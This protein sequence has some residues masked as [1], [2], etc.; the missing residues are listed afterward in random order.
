MIRSA[1]EQLWQRQKSPLLR[2]TS[3]C[4][5]ILTGTKQRL[6][7]LVISEWIKR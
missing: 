3:F 6:H 2:I 5:L 4:L 7:C 1:E